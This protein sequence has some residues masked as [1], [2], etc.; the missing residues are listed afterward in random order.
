MKGT[1]DYGIWYD[2]S[3]DFTLCTYTDANWACNIDYKRSTS[4]GTFFLEGRL[5]SWLSKKYNYISQSTT[6]VEYNVASNNYNQVMWMKQMLKD[7]GIEFIEFFM[8][9]YDN[10]SIVS[11]SKNLVL[12]S[13]KKT[14]LH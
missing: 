9:Y 12:H 10:T 1:F 4:G 8:I 13:K 11:M 6:E 7:I 3:S 14:H 2:R 5:V